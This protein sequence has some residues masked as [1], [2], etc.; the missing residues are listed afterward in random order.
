MPE[1]AVREAGGPMNRPQW[2]SLGAHAVSIGERA[3][4]GAT[5]NPLSRSVVQSPYETYARLRRRS[6]VHR[7]AILGSWV[8]TRYEDMVAAAKDHERFSNN[9]RWRET[10]R[11][12]LPPAPDDYSILL[13]DPPE[14]TRLRRCAAKAFSKAHLEALQETIAHTAVEL[15]ERAARRRTIDWIAEVAEPLAMRVM[16]AMMGLSRNEHHRWEVWSRSRARLLELIATRR[17]RKA[18]HIAGSEI[19]RYFMTLLGQRTQSNE[20]DAISTLARLAAAGEG[21]SMVEACDML[22]VL[23]IAGNETTTH[24]I[25]NG[26]LALVRN[27]EQMQRLREEPDRVRDAINEM[28]RF[29]SPVQTDFRIAKANVIVRGRTIKT[30]DGVILLTGSANRDEAAFEHPDTFDIGRKGPRHASFGHGVHQCI[31]AE[32]ARMEASAIFTE[33]LRTLGT[34]ELT[35]REPYYR[36]STVI[37]GLAALPLRVAA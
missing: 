12:V 32:L 27:R 33:A 6:P 23:M 26:M 28:L 34:I 5:Y 15:I 4:S 2:R 19:R 7:S 11:S 22:S 37:R 25:G 20:D 29:D 13:V 14:H 8:L 1:R 9:P 3:R 36:T 18:A 31:G 10:T 16:L 21:I 35:A 30:G 17:E 24:L